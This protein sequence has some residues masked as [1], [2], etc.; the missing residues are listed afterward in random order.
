[1]VIRKVEWLGLLGHFGPVLLLCMENLNTWINFIRLRHGQGL[2][3]NVVVVIVL[4][5]H[6]AFGPTF[7]SSNIYNF[8]TT[9]IK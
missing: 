6:L 4:L 9:F 2:G 5:G 3:C 8:L 7:L 1:M